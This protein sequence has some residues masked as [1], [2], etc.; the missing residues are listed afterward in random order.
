MSDR[1]KRYRSMPADLSLFSDKRL[2]NNSPHNLISD[3][4]TDDRALHRYRHGPVPEVLRRD[5]YA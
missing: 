4:P 3:S 1:D 2:L 5:E